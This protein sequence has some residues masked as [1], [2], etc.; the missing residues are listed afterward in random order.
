MR[1]CRTVEKVSVNSFLSRKL[2]LHNKFLRNETCFSVKKK[3][4]TSRFHNV[5]YNTTFRDHILGGTVACQS[6][7]RSSHGQHFPVKISTKL[8]TE[9]VWWSSTTYTVYVS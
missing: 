4:K 2:S 3:K 1:N 6:H 7:P 9:Y 8:K 5:S